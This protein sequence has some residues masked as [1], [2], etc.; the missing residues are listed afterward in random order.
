MQGNAAE[1]AEPAHQQ[2]GPRAAAAPDTTFISLSGRVVV[3]HTHKLVLHLCR[4]HLLHDVQLAVK[5][6]YG[7]LTVLSWPS[8]PSKLACA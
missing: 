6:M 5:G 3:G 8:V 2:A 7:Q 4:S 1:A